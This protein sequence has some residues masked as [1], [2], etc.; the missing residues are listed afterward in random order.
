MEFNPASTRA[1]AVEALWTAACPQKEK[2]FRTSIF[3]RTS[4]GMPYWSKLD[5]IGTTEIV[6]KR[7]SNRKKIALDPWVIHEKQEIKMPLWYIP[8]QGAEP[9]PN[10]VLE[11]ECELMTDAVLYL[12]EKNVIELCIEDTLQYILIHSIHF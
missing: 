7:C 5:Q 8:I 6:N 11:R 10:P 2:I 1:K 3:S 4:T 12:G 9:R